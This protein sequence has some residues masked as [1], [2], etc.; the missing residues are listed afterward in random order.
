MTGASDSQP[1]GHSQ[2]QNTAE[3]IASSHP[4]DKNGGQYLS[5]QDEPAVLLEQL[6]HCLLRVTCCLCCCCCKYAFVRAIWPVLAAKHANFRLFVITHS[7]SQTHYVTSPACT[8]TMRCA[9]TI[10]F[11]HCCMHCCQATQCGTEKSYCV[12]PRQQV[13]PH[14]AMALHR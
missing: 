12:A 3:A 1:K 11:L 6:L 7:F 5:P 14:H 13:G 8:L 9:C 10:S 2:W 4:G